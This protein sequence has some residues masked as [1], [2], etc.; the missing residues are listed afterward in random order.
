MLAI[1][2]V[3]PVFAEDMLYGVG[4]TQQQD[5]LYYG[6]IGAQQS[7]TNPASV[8]A[9]ACN[10]PALAYASS[11]S[12]GTGSPDSGTFTFTARWERDECPISLDPNEDNGGA[13]SNSVPFATIYARYGM[14]AYRDSARTL[15]MGESD[16]N[17][18]SAPVGKTITTKWYANKPSNAPEGS[19]VTLSGTAITDT[20]DNNRPGV[21][22]N[23]TRQFAGFYS[24]QTDGDQYISNTGYITSD[25]TN[26]AS[27]ITKTEGSC[28]VTTW[29]AHWN[30]TTRTDPTPTLTGYD[31]KGWYTTQYAANHPNSNTPVASDRTVCSDETLFAGWK[32]HEY[33]LKYVCTPGTMN[34]DVEDWAG[35]INIDGVQVGYDEERYNYGNGNILL[36]EIDDVCVLSTT[37]SQWNE[38]E[39]WTCFEDDTGHEVEYAFDTDEEGFIIPGP[40]LIAS[41]V[42]C[43]A[44][45]EGLYNL[46]YVCG[47][48]A[49]SDSVAPAGGSYTENAP[50]TIVANNETTQCKPQQGKHFIRWDC[51]NLRT[52]IDGDNATD[53][54]PI[55]KEDL[56]VSEYYM[57]NTTVT[58]TAKW[59][60]NE[61]NLVW[62]HDDEDDTV[63][64][65]TCT[66]GAAASEDGKINVPTPT[67]TGY[68][69]KGWLVTDYCHTALNA[70]GECPSPDEEEDDEETN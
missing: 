28:P 69:F 53:L 17:L 44:N 21:Y 7:S 22:V 18:T 11:Y 46:I 40:W 36:R 14:G 25:G 29:Y 10:I 42:T 32:N 41:D 4:T 24:G 34:P 20:S 56:P 57:P 59:E 8:G 63:Q 13:S 67:R 2:A 12:D 19:S 51:S 66:Y 55:L 65:G 6:Y 70:S 52:T 62:D 38:N 35:V 30:C 27:A 64:N 54:V 50:L 9:A 49:T 5:S 37:D 26:A 23:S 1:W 47:D 60:D 58:C 31:F 48:S 39:P 33:K 43:T 3:V 68:T 45:P 16:N 15:L 61:I